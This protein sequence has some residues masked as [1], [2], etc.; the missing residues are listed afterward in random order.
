M[1]TTSSKGGAAVVSAWVAMCPPKTHY[2]GRCEEWFG[3]YN[4]QGARGEDSWIEL[5]G[6]FGSNFLMSFSPYYLLFLPLRCEQIEISK[7]G[8][9]KITN[10]PATPK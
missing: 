8:K 4:Q 10:Y 9:T 2:C 1:A 7:N 3:G 5:F 6:I